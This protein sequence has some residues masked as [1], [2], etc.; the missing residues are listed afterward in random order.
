MGRDIKYYSGVEKWFSNINS[1]IKK[2]SKNDV[3]IKHYIIS[4][5]HAEI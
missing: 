1:Y 4:A 3:N 5:G 2:I